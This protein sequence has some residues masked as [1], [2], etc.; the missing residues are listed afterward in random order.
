MARRGFDHYQTSDIEII[1]QGY[2]RTVQEVGE[3]DNALLEVMNLTFLL[4]YFL[5]FLHTLNLSIIIT[6]ELIHLSIYPTFYL[7]IHPSLNVSRSFFVKVHG[8]WSN[9]CFGS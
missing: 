8:H 4:D 9:G 5:V 7:S 1:I 3:R 2:I 6:D